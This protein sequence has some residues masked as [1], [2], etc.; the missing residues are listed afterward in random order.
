MEAAAQDCLSW[1]LMEEINVRQ[2][3]LLQADD[4]DDLFGL[5]QSFGTI[6]DFL[7]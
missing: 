4:D 1:R 6:S 7:H 5:S 3:G 2:S